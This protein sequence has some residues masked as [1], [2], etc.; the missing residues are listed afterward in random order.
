[1]K[2]SLGPRGA[3][4]SLGASAAAASA[5][6][7]LWGM[8]PQLYCWAQPRVEL[9]LRGGMALISKEGVR[10]AAMLRCLVQAKRCL[11]VRGVVDVHT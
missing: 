8:G 4:R 10:V 9:L 2:R 3:P 5:R 6:A 7:S 1:M 11:T